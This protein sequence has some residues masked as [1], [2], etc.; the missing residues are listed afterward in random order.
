MNLN[1]ET[2]WK[3]KAAFLVS[4]LLSP[5]V[6]IP[7][8]ILLITAKYS[9]NLNDFLLYLGVTFIFSTLIPFLNVYIA[10]KKKKITDI[11]V[12]VREERVEP[13]VVAILSI[14]AGTF[15]LHL[16]G[17]PRE[18]VILGMVM[19]LNGLIFFVITLYWK[20][21]MHSSI[22]AGVLMSLMVLVSFR[23]VT[24]FL[25]FPILI[26]AR[27]RR[28]RHNIYQGLAATMLAVLGTYA[29]FRFFGLAGF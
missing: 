4:V 28:H 5:F 12:A 2:C 16:L 10:V 18:V 27:M 13:F 15:V 20:I 3:D 26:W 9:A 22:L 17:A 6:I 8:F 11:H 7:I 23:Y 19:L 25:L 1:K 14:A 21:S 24:G 29:L